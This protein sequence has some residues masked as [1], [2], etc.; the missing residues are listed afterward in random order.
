MGFLLPQS[1]AAI[2]AAVQAVDLHGD[3]WCDLTL[4]F[5]DASAPQRVRVSARDC[6]EG[7]VA[8]DAVEVRFVMGVA[9]SVRRPAGAPP[10]SA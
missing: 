9:T 2:V 8:G 4:R 7:L 6:P 1:R 3:R 5:S 10:P